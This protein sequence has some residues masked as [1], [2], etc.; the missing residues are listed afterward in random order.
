MAKTPSAKPPLRAARLALVLLALLCGLPSAAGALV[1]SEVMYDPVGGDAN[2]EWIEI[3]NDAGGPVDLS[4]YSLGWGIADYT[5][6]SLAL[7]SVT[8]NSGEYFLIGG[9]LSDPGNGSPDFSSP[10]TSLAVDL[11]PNLSNPFFFAAGV[12]LFETGV[13]N[14][15]H[16]VIYGPNNFFLV[17]ENGVI[18]LPDV[19]WPVF[20]NPPPSSPAGTSL[21]WDGTSWSAGNGATPGAGSLV[22]VPEAGPAVLTLL[23]LVGLATAGKPRARR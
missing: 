7:P 17:D 20:P 18:G 3:F 16:T 8:L 2:R 15:I 13:T 11:A 23:G 19:A 5:A 1:I 21:V 4:S 12:A 14:P 9:P 6:G 22:A 10:L